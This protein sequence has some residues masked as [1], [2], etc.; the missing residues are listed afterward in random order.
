[1]KKNQIK[2]FCSLHNHSHHSYM[3]GLSKPEEIVVAAKERGLK[4][5]ALTEHG[6]MNSFSDF[7]L[8]AKKHDFKTINGIEAYAIDDLDKW[9]KERDQLSEDKKALKQMKD[10]DLVDEDATNLNVDGRRKSLRK[11]GHLVL[12]AQNPKG[13]ENLFQLTFKSHNDGFYFKPRVDKKMIAEHSEGVIAS[14]ACMGGII[15]NKC[16]AYKRGE[17]DWKEVVREAEEYR[18]IFGD[19]F[20]L[21]LQFN[22]SESQR[23]I[24]DCLIRVHKE[25][26][27]PMDVTADAH[28]INHDDWE[29]QEIL[30]MLRSKPVKTLKTRGD[31]WN[32]EIKQLF[33]KS[34][35]EMWDAYKRFGGDADEKIVRQAFENT[36]LIDS[37]IDKYDIDTSMRLPTLEQYPDGFRALGENTIKQMKARGLDKDPKYVTRFATEMRLIKDKGFANY[38]L[39]V[40]EIVKKAKEDMLVGVGRGCLA[41]DSMVH[42]PNGLSRLD[43]IK[44]G[45]KVFDGNGKSC[46]VANAFE[47]DVDEDLIEI[48]SYYGGQPIKMTKDHKVLVSKHTKETN[49]SKIA[50]GYKWKKEF[51]KPEWIAAENIEV[52]DLVV[53]PKTSY[54][55]S[56]EDFIIKNNVFERRKN[57][58]GIKTL[59]K[60]AGVSESVV[61]SFINPKRKGRGSRE[62]LQNYIVNNNINIY[63][64]VSPTIK[65]IV[66]KLIKPTYNVGK[67]F[68][69]W[70]SDGWLRKD[71]SNKVGFCCKRSEDDGEILNLIYDVF[72]TRD[73]HI[74]DHKTKDLRQFNINHKG[75]ENFFRETFRN[76]KFTSCTKYIPKKFFHYNDEFKFGLLHGLWKGDG[77]HKGKTKYVTISK[78][79]AED[80]FSLLRTLG[81][82]ASIKKSE[83]HEKRENFR[84]NKEW[85][86]YSIVSSPNFDIPKN[87]YGVSYD[88]EYV[89]YRVKKINV[90][91]G[92]KKVYDIEVPSTNSY[93][94]N[95]FVVHNSAAASL[96]CYLNGIT[97]LNPIEHNLMFERFL[98]PNR[99][100]YPDIDIDF[101]DPDE[102]KAKLREWFGDKNV[103]CIS[104]YSTFNIK[105]LL[106]D[107]GRVY[108]VPHQEIN[109]FNK[110]IEN[111][112]SHLTKGRAPSYAEILENSP[113]Y[114]ELIKKHP[115]IERN[116][117]KLY[118]R[119]RHVGRHAA[120]VIIGDN[121]P[122]EMPLFVSKE[123]I[124]TPYTQGIVNKN[125]EEMGFI[126][127]DILGLATLGVLDHALKLI[128][129]KEGISFDEAKKLI[130]PDN[131][132]L[133]DQKV[134]QTVFCNGNTSGIFQFGKK[135][136]TKVTEHIH[137]ECFNDIAAINAIYRP[138][139]LGSDMDKLYAD[140]K[141]NK[142]RIEYIHP[143]MEDILKE[144]HGCLIYQEQTMMIGNKIGKLNMKDTNKL[145][146]LLVKRTKSDKTVE[147]ETERIKN[148]F[149]KGCQ[150]SGLTEKQSTELWEQIA[151][152][153]GYGFNTVAKNTKLA[154]YRKRKKKNV[155]INK[156]RVGDFVDSRNEMT[157]E[158]IKVR[159]LNVFKKG[160]KKL[161]RFIFEDGETVECTM[162]HK[163]RT[164]C[165][166]MLPIRKIIEKDLSVVSAKE[167]KVHKTK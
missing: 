102:A 77:T 39:V 62:K 30:Y 91:S 106:K 17:I 156:V 33:I 66:P 161:H 43:S 100:D 55:N 108:D 125:A 75:L 8:A 79:L 120:G 154:I 112:I 12:L 164:T 110:K 119:N 24:N 31:N 152:F 53:C 71:I 15:S 114:N 18:D 151:K 61:K 127:F 74:N 38:F 92:I 54:E 157:G 13:L 96:V 136:I 141:S 37:M 122:T 166:Q 21:E 95:S 111:E 47:Y 14:S 23:Y 135:G 28:Y 153:A 146:K 10:D 115:I 81:L 94:T 45:D 63:E 6:H 72:S 149:I 158:Y 59:A 159:V 73:V 22:E 35:E 124:Q 142:D 9:L 19:R 82:H 109:D 118:G 65:T 87:M 143:L 4:S 167:E 98:D 148:L 68:G 121:L 137:P 57:K 104:N 36:L 49:K 89:Y 1:M 131:M 44:K 48:D 129:K 78:Q 34:P 117:K 116:I 40:K 101:K 132:D 80:V 41:G 88:G 11:K 84:K 99:D 144:T 128:S 134:L 145:R 113:T 133:N 70:I 29:A 86:E 58:K 147:A 103:A 126:K 56:Y 3:D 163:F 25:T 155:T 162:D 60:L 130:E 93:L 67:L 107:L 105:S 26:G 165:G 42:T 16:W 52:G 2:E 32:F 27:I 139:P 7:Y 160:K 138:G 20:F 5:I 85:V 83:R 50:Q 90:I 140:N 46:I 51:S 64:Y 150:E 97:G 76:Y 123:T 69:L